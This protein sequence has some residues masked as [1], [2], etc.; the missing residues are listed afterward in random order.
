MSR[1][2]SPPKSFP[3]IISAA[4]GFVTPSDFSADGLNRVI[5]TMKAE[6]KTARTIQGKTPNG[7]SRIRTCNQGIMSPLL[8]R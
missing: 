4:A 6:D 1:G 2:A 3:S 8:C 5:A 7:P